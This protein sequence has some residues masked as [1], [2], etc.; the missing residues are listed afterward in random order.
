MTCFEPSTKNIT[1]SKVKGL[2][3][4][5]GLIGLITLKGSRSRSRS[6]RRWSHS[7]STS[8]NEFILHSVSPWQ[9]K[10]ISWKANKVHWPESCPASTC[11]VACKQRSAG[12]GASKEHSD[13]RLESSSP[14]TKF[15]FHSCSWSFEAPR[16]ILR[17][18]P[19]RLRR[20]QNRAIR[21]WVILK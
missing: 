17:T 9:F 19:Y 12:T 1:G 16:W 4:A 5:S 8:T 7:I 18:F 10:M 6:P 3:S 15:Y 20:N 21:W 2:P 14:I 11:K 13:I